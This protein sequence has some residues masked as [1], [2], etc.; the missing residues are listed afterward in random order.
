MRR[1]LVVGRIH[2][3]LER[4]EQVERAGV[5]EGQDLGE[6]HAGDAARRV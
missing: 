3:A 2:R 6:Q 5:G 1:R 4:P